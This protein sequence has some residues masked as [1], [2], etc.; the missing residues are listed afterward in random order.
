MT[1]IMKSTSRFLIAAACLVA[2]PA[3]AAD[4][5]SAPFVIPPS[6]KPA[7]LIVDKDLE[8]PTALAFDSLNRPY[9]FER[10]EPEH[11]GY[12]LTLRNGEWVRLDY[13]K[14]LQKAFP[15]VTRPK[16]RMHHAHGTLAID[17]KD[18]IYA[19][20][21]AETKWFLLYSEDMGKRFHVTQLPGKSFLETYTGH[22]NLD[23]PPAVGC[24]RKRKDHPARWT[25][26]HDLDIYFPA[27]NQEGL[28]FKDP[29]HVT[30]NCFGVSNHSG[31]Y[32][33]SIT[34]DGKTHVTYAEIP[35]DGKGNPTY[36]A[37]IDRKTMQVTAKRFVLNAPPKKIDVHST[38]VITADADGTLHLLSG[39]HNNPFLYTRSAATVNGKWS[40]C[41]SNERQTDLCHVG[42]RLKWLSSLR[43]PATRQFALRIQVARI[44][45]MVPTR[46]DR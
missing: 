19:V 23:V 45:L 32:S 40:A 3:L 33:F 8:G 12:I 44:I 10:R 14:D 28:Q 1:H 20:V 16:E 9:M 5:S 41:A 18:R 25:S 7:A 36:V 17:G 4:Q 27:K 34:R 37:T 39:A 38:P 15:E 24:L 21:M 13:L 26:Y 46:G 31:G 42:M 11:F 6:G 30:A 35:K 29:V 43:L 22:N 2:C